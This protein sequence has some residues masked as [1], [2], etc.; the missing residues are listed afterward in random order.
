M[1]DL[2]VKIYL[3]NSEALDTIIINYN[4]IDMFFHHLFS[5]ELPYIDKSKED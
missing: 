1:P 2:A 4:T 3:Q 5:D